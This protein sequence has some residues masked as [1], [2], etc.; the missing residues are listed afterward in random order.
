[1]RLITVVKRETTTSNTCSQKKLNRKELY[2]QR[3][4]VCE[5]ERRER[6]LERLLYFLLLWFVCRRGT[7][8]RLFEAYLWL[9]LIVRGTQTTH[10]QM[11]KELRAESTFRTGGSI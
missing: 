7:S 3:E 10:I 4:S 6:G 11:E 2:D 9:L 5:R 1:M 8:P